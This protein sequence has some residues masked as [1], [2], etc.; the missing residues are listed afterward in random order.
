MNRYLKLS[1]FVFELNKIMTGK[2]C[3]EMLFDWLSNTGISYLY[4]GNLV[5]THKIAIQSVKQKKKV[6]KL[7]LEFSI[8]RNI[9][10]NIISR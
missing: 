8:L 5:K 1:Y 6:D 10:E 4:Y 9:Q 3:L 7:D 2:Y